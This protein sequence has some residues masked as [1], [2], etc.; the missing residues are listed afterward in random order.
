[1]RSTE[2]PKEPEKTKETEKEFS[3][4]AKKELKKLEGKWRVV[5][6]VTADKEG[7]AKDEEAYFTFKGTELTLSSTRTGKSETVRITAIDL[8]TDPRSASTFWK[9]AKEGLTR[10]LKECTDRW[11]NA[12]ISPFSVL[13]D[14]KNRPTSFEKPGERVLVWTLKQVKE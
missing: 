4:D 7:E 5:K 12:S 10:R 13:R 11:R 6:L 14:G 3:D 8:T 1:M 9:N 2:P